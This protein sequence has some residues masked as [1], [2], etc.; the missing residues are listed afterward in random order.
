MR[1]RERRERQLELPERIRAR[2]WR[3]L[4][5]E[6]ELG[7]QPLTRFSCRGRLDPAHRTTTLW[8]S[9]EVGAKHMLEEPRPTLTAR[10][11][12]IVLE[13]L[14]LITLGGRRPAQGPIMRRLRNDFGAE[15]RVA[16]KEPEV[17]QQM[18]PWSWHCS[19]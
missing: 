11:S 16:R 15:R 17:A 8:T 19:N 18:K 6:A 10:R 4:R 1:V 2:R 13:E 3:R 12:S 14:E 7:E 5:G 9:I